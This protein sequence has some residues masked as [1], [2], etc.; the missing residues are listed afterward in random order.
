M[1]G[2]P[3]SCSSFRDESASATMMGTRTAA[4]PNSKRRSLLAIFIGTL[5]S[6]AG[7][8]F[9]E[10]PTRRRR[11]RHTRSL[12]TCGS[13]LP[14]PYTAKPAYP[15]TADIRGVS[16]HGW[17]SMYHLLPGKKY[18]PSRPDGLR[19]ENLVVAPVR[20]PRPASSASPWPK[21]KMGQSPAGAVLLAAGAS[22][23]WST[24]PAELPLLPPADKPRAATNQIASRHGQTVCSE[25]AKAS[26][27][28]WTAKDLGRWARAR[29]EIRAGR[30]CYSTCRAPA[31]D[32]TRF[33][34]KPQPQ[35]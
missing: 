20:G 35:S 25:Y 32:R 21:E 13:A 16:G 19:C 22:G 29:C 15:A 1:L 6:Q 11:G 4:A 7:P 24:P 17:V 9:P 3:E 28:S 26:G 23:V 34:R 8:A 10:N 5:T 33:C 30:E 31:P 2:I 14:A 27:K 12:Q 18:P